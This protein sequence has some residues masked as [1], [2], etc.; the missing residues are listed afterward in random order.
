MA[1][2]T[3]QATAEQKAKI[4]ELGKKVKKAESE[5]RKLKKQFNEAAARNERVAPV[6]TLLENLVNAAYADD[7]A[8]IEQTAGAARAFLDTTPA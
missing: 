5:V 6:F 3:E 8:A 7:P 1:T 2:K 4:E